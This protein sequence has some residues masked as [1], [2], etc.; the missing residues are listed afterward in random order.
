M[1]WPCA[2]AAVSVSA[3]CAV[4]VAAEGG[5]RMRAYPGS[6]PAELIMEMCA[7]CAFISPAS[8]PPGGGAALGSWQVL[9]NTQRDAACLQRKTPLAGCARKGG[10]EGAG[11]QVATRAASHPA[12]A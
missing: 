1:W 4:V 3:E 10:R 12:S 9:V 5:L 8:P 6:A 2:R 7:L 11:W